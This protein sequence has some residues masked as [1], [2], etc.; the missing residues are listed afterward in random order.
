[1]IIATT[2]FNNE[3]YF[4]NRLFNLKNEYNGCIYGTP[5]RISEKIP[6]HKKII[7]I[8]MNND[9]NQIMGI[10]CIINHLRY[11]KDSNIHRDR[12]FNRFLYKGLFKRYSRIELDKDIVKHLD[13]ILFKTSGH[14]KRLRGITL[15]KKRRLGEVLDTNFCIGD[16]VK[17]IKPKYRGKTGIVI[18][19]NKDKI[20]VSYLEDG[21]NKI[22]SSRYAVTNYIKLNKTLKKRKKT[23]KKCFYRC[24]LCGEIKKQHNCIAVNYSKELRDDIYE[25]LIRLFALS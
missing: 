9:L 19:K 25:Y 16:L 3:T 4:E 8:E 13:Y 15:I 5:H 14:Y 20:T 22:W 6:I 21:V 17:N 7:V 11:Y 24:R 23:S 1:M 18:K 12:K 2:R 10:G